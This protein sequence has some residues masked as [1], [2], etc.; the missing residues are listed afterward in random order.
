[1]GGG[2]GGV[3]RLTEAPITSLPPDKAESGGQR[4][5]TLVY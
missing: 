1:M 2:G 3:A 5:R 4:M